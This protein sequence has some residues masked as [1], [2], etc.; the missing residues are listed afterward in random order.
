MSGRN[1]N[2]SAASGMQLSPDALAEL[3]KQIGEMSAKIQNI[4]AELVG[5]GRPGLV[6]RVGEL[7]AYKMKLSG[8]LVVLTFLLHAGTESL[9]AWLGIGKAH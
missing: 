2:D 8:G 9:K 5:N 4:E 1:P 7:E 3:F 6:K